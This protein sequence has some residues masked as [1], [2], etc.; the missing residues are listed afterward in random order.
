MVLGLLAG[1]TAPLILKVTG[2][3]T[4]IV[5]G[6]HDTKKQLGF[7]YGGIVKK[8]GKALVHKGE[9][10]IPAKDVKKMELDILLLDVFTQQ[11]K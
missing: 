6:I 1:V 10:V 9:F 4:K 2:L 5:K 11:G 8:T 7:K 3:D